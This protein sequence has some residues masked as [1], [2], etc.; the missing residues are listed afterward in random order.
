MQKGIFTI[1]LDFELFWGVRDH[2]TIGN[3]GENI[4]NV[5]LVVPRLLQLFEKYSI[6]SSWATIGFLFL[7]NREELLSNLP[8]S[9]PEYV[10]PEY[11]PYNYIRQNE[12][13]PV[14]HF[15]LPLIEQIKNTP[16]QEICTHTFSHFYALEKNTSVD[17]FTADIKAAIKAAM[18]NN[19]KILSIVFPRNQYSD[20][21]IKACRDLGIQVY[22][23]NEEAGAYRP[24]SRE[25]ENVFR[26]ALRLAD[27]YI[28]ITGHHCHEIPKQNE[29][30]NVPASRFLRPH[31]KKLKFLDSLKFN[32]IKN[33]M[34]YAAD[35]GLIYQLWWHPHNFGSNMEQNFIFL[36]DIL[37]VYYHLNLMNKMVSQNL[38]EIFSQTL[39][40][41]EKN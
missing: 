30:I 15:A 13:E 12:L 28:N 34:K 9:F 5:H 8:A 40:K 26:R 19:I 27:T 38:N 7:N 39:L 29:I 41:H 35:K 11:D 2:R 37:K 17:Q 24:V 4:K 21:H 14:Y 10:K 36:E 18:K 23:G 1:S 25:D 16:G 32:R 22:R 31:N 3:Y 20:V 33:S 6:H